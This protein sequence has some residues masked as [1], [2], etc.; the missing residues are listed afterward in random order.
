MKSTVSSYRLD[1]DGLRAIAIL[2]V[3]VNHINRSILPGGY[4]GVDMF[5]VISG[6]VITQS[7]S[8]RKYN[9]F[10]D[11][12]GGFYGRRAKRLVPALCLF[13]AV[14]CVLTL[15]FVSPDSELSRTSIR[16]GW[17]SLFGLS[18]ISLFRHATDYFGESAELNSFTHT[19]SL[20]VEEQFYLVFPLLI[21][22]GGWTRK[23]KSGYRN[24]FII[25]SVSGMASFALYLWMQQHNPVWA[26]YMMPAR[27]WEL[28]LGAII[29]FASLISFEIADISPKVVKPVHVIAFLLLLG[30][31]WWPE[32]QLH[33]GLAT[34]ISVLLTA[35][36]ICCFHKDS[37]AYKLLTLK[38]IV[39]IGTISYSLYLWHWSVL[40]VSRLTVGVT[41]KTLPYQLALMLILA[42]LS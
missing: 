35:F 28:S 8:A 17:T 2:A 7:L 14:T 32:A 20:G 27:F 29:Y 39:F 26:F 38:P 22:L 19:W 23:T 34:T 30:V 10:F 33:Q 16:T 6:F 5:F 37:L 24:T 11:Y 36:L 40:V 13:V 25:I 18:N 21:W 4:L 3:I 42:S 1:I 9:S 15:L 31:F 41:P 12:I